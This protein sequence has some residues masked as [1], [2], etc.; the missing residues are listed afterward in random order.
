MSADNMNFK[1]IVSAV[2][3]RSSRTGL[4]ARVN[5]HEPRNAPGSKITTAIWVQSIGPA[6]SGLASTSVRLVLM[7]RIFTSMLQD[8][9]EMIDFAVVHAVDVVLTALSAD[10]DL[11]GLVRCIDLLGLNGATPLSAQAGYLNQDAKLFRVMDI[12]IP[13]ILNDIWTQG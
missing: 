10:V 13:L 11:G 6:D 4:F 3:D 8:P 5:K 2:A 12:T 9:V 1:G 7:Q